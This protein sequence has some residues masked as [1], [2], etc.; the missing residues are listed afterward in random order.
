M[1]CSELGL[2]GYG[3]GFSARSECTHAV[4]CGTNNNNIK[5]C[6]CRS[7]NGRAIR[8]AI[9]LRW[10]ET[11]AHRE[12]R[13]MGAHANDVSFGA[14]ILFCVLAVADAALL[15]CA[16]A[17]MCLHVRVARDLHALYARSR[18]IISRTAV[19]LFAGALV[20]WMATTTVTVTLCAKEPC[21]SARL[22]AP[23]A[24]ST[25]ILALVAIAGAASVALRAV[26]VAID[27]ETL[28]M[29]RY[30]FGTV[31]GAPHKRDAHHPLYAARAYLRS[32]APTA[33]RW[34]ACGGSLPRLPLSPYVDE[35]AVLRAYL[36]LLEEADVAPN[37]SSSAAVPAASGVAAAAAAA[38]ASAETPLLPD[39]GI[40]REEAQMRASL[41][42]QAPYT[43]TVSV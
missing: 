14:S 40:A 35:R 32:R 17:N 41:L 25:G 19:R 8:A 2:G 22:C 15:L 27:G 10:R 4:R 12:P 18:V 1:P 21:A 9:Y 39:G 42:A 36:R 5:G 34:C 11:V 26:T 20:A 3:G 37:G 33:V 29:T 43:A 24:A 6:V 13:T 7:V 38:A 31:M 30:S 28:E 16:A 23:I